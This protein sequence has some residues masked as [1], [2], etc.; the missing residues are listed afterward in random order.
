[1]NSDRYNIPKGTRK[2]RTGNYVIYDIDF[3]LDN[4][5]RE[6]YLL[7]ESRKSR[8]HKSLRGDTN[9]TLGKGCLKCPSHNTCPDAFQM[10]S[11]GCGHYNLTEEEFE[12]L[13]KRKEE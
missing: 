12:K 8:T 9:F 6:V 2:I 7:E 1:M 4:L 13:R 10:H 11:H 5:S 3:L